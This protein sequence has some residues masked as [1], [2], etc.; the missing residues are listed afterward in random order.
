MSVA[1]SAAAADD[2]GLGRNTANQSARPVVPATAAIAN[3][4][5]RGRGLADAY[6]FACEAMF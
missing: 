1:A 5:E 6:A 2:H 4:F 3:I